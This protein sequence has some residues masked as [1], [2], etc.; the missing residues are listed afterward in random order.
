[1]LSR[2]WSSGF[3]VWIEKL[4][5]KQTLEWLLKDEIVVLR[6]DRPAS[7]NAL[8]QQLVSEIGRALDEIQRSPE[9]RGVVLSS[10]SERAFSAGADLKEI[11]TLTH[12][13]FLLANRRGAELFQRIEEF[14]LPI[15]AVI[16]GYALGGGFELALASDFR[17][18]DSSAVLGLPEILAGFIPGW[19]G[20]KRLCAIVGA[21]K[22]RELV[23]SGVKLESERAAALGL[24][25]ELPAADP[26][27]V[28]IAR[29]RALPQASNGSVAC[30]KHL[31]SRI[32][33]EAE[34]ANLST[35][36]VSELLDEK[37]RKKGG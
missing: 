2:K 22:A 32:V 16:R 21:A 9:I 17:F 14:P 11:D 19:G 15:A 20:I 5:Q 33:N 24:F 12:A 18:A 6:L 3:Q 4:E 13:D 30:I 27:E 23:L 1:M 29:L 7:L 26:E 31:F 28:A 37:T 34:F 36:L 8:N 25:S 35:L 10:T